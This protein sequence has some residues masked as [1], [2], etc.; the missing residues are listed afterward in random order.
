MLLYFPAPTT[1]T[2]TVFADVDKNDFGAKIGFSASCSKSDLFFSKYL[3]TR[4]INSLSKA[5]FS[6]QIKLRIMQANFIRQ[7]G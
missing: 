4:K 2:A 1:T 6:I 7:T 5:S 3:D